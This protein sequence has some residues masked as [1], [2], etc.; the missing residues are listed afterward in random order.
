MQL[1]NLISDLSR[2]GE[3][4]ARVDPSSVTLDV[5]ARLLMAE[6]DGAV[7]LVQPVFFTATLLAAGRE[8]VDLRRLREFLGE[9]GMSIAGL[10]VF[11]SSQDTGV[12]GFWPSGKLYD[13]HRGGAV[14]LSL[15]IWRGLFCWGR[16]V[17]KSVYNV[18][19]WS[20]V[21]HPT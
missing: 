4:T 21:V 13:S 3:S 17:L 16:A 8:Y 5:L 2:V 14:A 18:R 12:E 20:F 6:N 1:S 15:A 19:R 9:R 10:P 11:P 7:R